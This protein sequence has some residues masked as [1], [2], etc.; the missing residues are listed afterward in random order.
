MQDRLRRVAE[1]PYWRYPTLRL[2][3]VNWYAEVYN[4]AV[5]GHRRPGL[6]PARPA[7]AAR[8]VRRSIR[9]PAPNTAGS[10]GPGMQFHYLPHGL[11]ALEAQR[12]FGRVREHRR[13]GRALL[14]QRDRARHAPLPAADEALL[15]RWMTRV[16][17]GYWTHGGY[18]NWDTG[19][20]FGAGTR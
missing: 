12:R 4:A 2:N 20:G 9:S 3:Q 18:L 10:L 6:P 13:L 8:S 5:A 17:A 11:A 19:F 7:R 16:L 15:R 1:G 14:R